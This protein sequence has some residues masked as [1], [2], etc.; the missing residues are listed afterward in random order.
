MTSDVVA[1]V[2]EVA[3]SIFA[4]ADM[5][6]DGFDATSWRSLEAAGFTRLTVPESAGGGGAGLDLAAAVLLEAGAH[7]ARVPLAETD[8]LAGWLLAGAGIALPAGPLTAV[9]AVA[10]VEHDISRDGDGWRIRAELSGVPWAGCAAGVAV[11]TPRLV[12]LLDTCQ[13]VPGR[14]LAGEPRDT[15]VIDG[16]VG[17][18]AVVEADGAVLE[19]ELRLRAALARTQLLA[20]ALSATLS[21]AVRYAGERTQFGRPIARFQAV[22]QQLALA[23][24]EVAAACSAAEAAAAAAT[25]AGV[26]ADASVIAIASAKARAS[27]AAGAVAAIAHQVHGAIGF[28]LEHPLRVLTT[29]L[30]AWRDEDGSDA[31]WNGVIGARA[32]SL[33]PA[34]LW[35]MLTGT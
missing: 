34:G 2:R 10:G 32:L 27:E 9:A 4:A 8:L 23:A 3:A 1:A 15:V 7:A 12:V 30:W 22:Q 6:G 19:D 18:D 31:Y 26:T 29:R 28:T 16:F 25:R 11:L 33:G 17:G 20:G 13:V 24:G 14:N 35:P 5:S 21:A